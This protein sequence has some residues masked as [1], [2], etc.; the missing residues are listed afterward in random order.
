VDPGIVDDAFQSIAARREYLQAVSVV[1][2][3]QVGAERQHVADVS[4]AAKIGAVERA[5]HAT[6]ET[7][8]TQKVVGGRVHDLALVPNI[9]EVPAHALRVRDEPTRSSEFGRSA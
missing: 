7:D 8:V 6:L 3:A 2:V 5:Q 9:L 1:V 4:A